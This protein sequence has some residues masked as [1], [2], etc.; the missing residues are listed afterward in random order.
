MAEAE[1]AASRLGV[2]GARPGAS[3]FVLGGGVAKLVFVE[4]CAG[5]VR[6]LARGGGLIVLEVLVDE[7]DH[8]RWVDHPDAGGEVLAP[9]RGRRRSGRCGRGRGSRR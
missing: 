9:V 8:E 4:A 1:V 3:L 7:V 6:L 2:A 5:E